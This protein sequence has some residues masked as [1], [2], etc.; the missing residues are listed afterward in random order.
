MGC[1]RKVDTHQC[2][3]FFLGSKAC[4]LIRTEYLLVSREECEKTALNHCVTQGSLLP[5]SDKSMSTRNILVPSF[6]WPVAKTL[7]V[8]N[9][10]MTVLNV[11]K[12]ITKH[13]SFSHISLGKLSCAIARKTC[14]SESWRVNYVENRVNS[15]SLVPRVKNATLTIHETVQ[16]RMYEVKEANIVVSVFTRCLP[17]AVACIGNQ[18]AQAVCTLSGHVLIIPEDCDVSVSDRSQ[19]EAPASLRFISNAIS[20]ASNGGLLNVCLL[21]NYV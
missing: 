21:E 1:H 8:R 4:S 17:N 15:C 13:D 18:S 7:I 16:R 19:I 2:V 10:Q 9:F 5:Q 20:T 6:R 11:M 3:Y 14:T 12:D